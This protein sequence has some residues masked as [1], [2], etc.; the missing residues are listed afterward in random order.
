MD[1]DRG[2]EYASNIFN[3]LFGDGV[4]YCFNANISNRGNITNMDEGACVEVPALAS[5]YGITPLGR[6]TLPQGLAALIGHSSRIEGL[7]VSAAIEGDPQKVLEAVML[8]PLTASVCSMQEI[9]DMVS[10][11]LE[12]NAPY[13]GYFKTL[14]I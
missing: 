13:L 14:K 4:P 7:A 1:L 11:M 2:E 6:I 10:E 9:H 5:R 8:D 12:R 3:T